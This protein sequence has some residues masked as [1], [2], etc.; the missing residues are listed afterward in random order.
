MQSQSKTKAVGLISGGL[1]STIAAKIIQDLGIEVY[2]VYFSMPW[3]CCH[4][5][6]AMEVCQK[7]GIH[8]VT[9]QLDERY[10]EI[11]KN[12]RFGRGTAM[13]PCVDCRI[14]MFS[15]AAKYMRQIGAKFVFT[16]EVL[17]QRP[18]SQKR[19][20]MKIIEIESDLEGRLLRPLSA[21]V[22]DPTIVEQDGIVDRDKL[23]NLTGRSRK[24]QYRLAESFGIKE[25]S[26][27]A[28]GCSLTDH[29][30]SRRLQD[31]F[32]HGYR[33]FQETVALKWGRHFR[34][35]QF[36]K[37][38]LGRDENENNA[39]KHFAHQDDWIMQFEHQ[40]GP[41]LVLKG[42]NPPEEIFDLCAG[43]I[44][45]F[46]KYKDLEPQNIKYWLCRNKNDVFERKSSQITE[47]IVKEYAI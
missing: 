10:L 20:K 1:D 4:K 28:G 24:D 19:Q 40:Q 3:G 13:N 17:G 2:G 46:S 14:H 21:Q 12:P 44:K 16:G 22:L 9:L 31:T 8:L 35:N 11:V 6:H 32:E 25:F 5:T 41:T 23:L 34:F 43:L 42:E 27:P 30:F 26:A 37:C 47:N 33:N 45:Y 36:Y 18:M 15:R 39:L 38:V 29:N 7:L